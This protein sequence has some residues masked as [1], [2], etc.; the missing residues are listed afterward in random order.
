MKIK[1]GLKIICFATEIFEQKNFLLSKFQHHGN[2]MELL[3]N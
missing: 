3:I 2:H 1:Q